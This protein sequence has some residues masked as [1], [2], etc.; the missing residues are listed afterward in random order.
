MQ[1]R[2]TLLCAYAA[3]ANIISTTNEIICLLMDFTDTSPLQWLRASKTGFFKSFCGS[4]VRGNPGA[5]FEAFPRSSPDA[6]EAIS[7]ETA[8]PQRAMFE[9]VGVFYSHSR[10]LACARLF[11]RYEGH[12]GAPNFLHYGIHSSPLDRHRARVPAIPD[13]ALPLAPVAYRL[14]PAWI[15]TSEAG[16]CQYRSTGHALRTSARHSAAPP[17]AHTA[18]PRRW[19][20]CASLPNSSRQDQSLRV[21]WCN[22]W[23][24]V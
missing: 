4:V 8:S 14:S 21:E 5:F 19:F 16:R 22:P 15:R 6:I 20:Q 17:C 24:C 1:Y 18:A 9:Y 11:R 3:F 23:S 2:V 7:V 12:P 13:R 10:A